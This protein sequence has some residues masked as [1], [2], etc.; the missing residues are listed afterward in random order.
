M[1]RRQVK[2]IQ[3]TVPTSE[4]K[5]RE[6]YKDYDYSVLKDNDY[7]TFKYF[8]NIQND[9]SAFFDKY[10]KNWL[11]ILTDDEGENYNRTPAYPEVSAEMNAQLDEIQKEFEAN[12]RGMLK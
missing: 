5:S 12:P 1:K 4:V 11:H 9:N 3:Y 2:A 7:I 6:E 8:K 10:R